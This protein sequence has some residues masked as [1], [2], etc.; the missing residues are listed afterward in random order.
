MTEIRCVARRS[1]THR[2]IDGYRRLR[3]YC[4]EMNSNFFESYFLS[5]VEN[6][7]VDIM[8]AKLPVEALDSV[9]MELQQD[10]TKLSDVRRPFNEVI[11]V[12]P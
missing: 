7:R 9:T 11:C 8:I 12:F 1:S 2:K 6:H 10:G 5:P 4:P 3:E